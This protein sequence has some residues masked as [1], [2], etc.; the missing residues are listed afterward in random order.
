V[1][2]ESADLLV[3]S[4]FPQRIS[5]DEYENLPFQGLNLHGSI[6]PGYRG[7]NSE[8]WALIN[9]ERELG[10]TVHKLSYDY[11]SGEIL[12]IYRI[13]IDDS[14]SNHQIYDRL[15]SLIPL[16]VHDLTYGN[17]LSC[18]EASTGPSVYW[19][20]RE[21]KDS[22]LDWC[23]SARSLFLFVRALGRPPI[24][25]YAF[26][27]SSKIYFK[28]VR[29]SDRFV[30]GQPGTVLYPE[31]TPCVICGDNLLLEILDYSGPQLLSGQAL[32]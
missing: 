2:S 25:A 3:S 26:V 27:G 24:Y 20:R 17:L 10:I 21:L 28:D 15:F 7:K 5:N 4:A 30:Q 18:R 31:I 9:D 13:P 32:A 29:V 12:K 22:H 1:L 23:Q 8:V 14:L 11:D 16:I 19:R 6:L